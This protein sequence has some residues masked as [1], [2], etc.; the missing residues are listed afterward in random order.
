M[1]VFPHPVPAL[2]PP[3]GDIT[4]TVDEQPLD[5]Y[6]AV[7]NVTHGETNLTTTTP[8]GSYT[9]DAPVRIV[10]RTAF[11]LAS[12]V[13]R[14]LRLGLVPEI[15]ADR[16]S[17]AFTAPAHEKIS[18]EWSAAR[19]RELHLFGHAPAASI[20]PPPG[21]GVRVFTAG[22]HHTGEI[23][24]RSGETIFLAPGAIIYGHIRAEHASDL[25]I[26]GPG[27]LDCHLSYAAWAR[28]PRGREPLEADS[29][30]CRVNAIR[31][32]RCARIAFR[33]VLV[34][35]NAFWTCKFIACEDLA[36][37]GVKLFGG[38]NNTDGFD[39]CGCRRATL[40]HCFTRVWDDSVVLKSFGDG[41]LEDI[42]VEH[43][44]FWN[45]HAQTLE[46]GF[47]L[48]CG[49]VRRVTFRDIDVLHNYWGGVLT[50]HN[51][52]Q[53]TVSDILYENIRIEDCHAWIVEHWIG[54]SHWH[55]G[56]GRGRIERVTY[57][58]IAVLGHHDRERTLGFTGH[59]AAHRSDAIVFENLRIHGRLV[60]SLA[61]IGGRADAHLGAL[62][63]R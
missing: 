29:H 19:G 10:V 46:I 42:L 9:A 36:I 54:A 17:L 14:P 53:A 40:R 7:V 48:D 50:I 2:H 30:T 18:L 4:V 39:L 11:D 1:P 15:A 43:C 25:T 21:P 41:D 51:G 63:F 57:R 8:V 58:D 34:A 60:T 56:A 31:L 61:D 38:R 5:L 22:I 35:D 24:L 49:H 3:V 28:T 20:A 27:I 26:A 23:R 16:R 12:V 55:E 37:D 59:D 32:E 52:N 6:E 13:V 47:E 33:D 44:Q 45:D 62:A